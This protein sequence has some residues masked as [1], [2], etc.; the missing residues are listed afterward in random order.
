MRPNPSPQFSQLGTC[1]VGLVPAG[2]LPYAG[3]VQRH[4]LRCG[5]C[6]T[7]CVDLRCLLC[8]ELPLSWLCLGRRGRSGA[9]QA[10]S[11]GSS[12]WARIL[13]THPGRRIRATMPFCRL[14][15][16]GHLG[17]VDSGHLRMFALS[18]P[19]RFLDRLVL[20]HLVHFAAVGWANGER[21]DSAG[22]QPVGCSIAV[23][24]TI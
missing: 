23:F 10:T 12:S 13:Y 5:T 20:H 14:S 6:Q 19:P 24:L 22:D 2:P 7:R 8:R 1:S 9:A 16:G 3:L 15:Y 18:C 17:R 21:S 11:E 4:R